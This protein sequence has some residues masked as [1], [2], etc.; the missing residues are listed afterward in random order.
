MSVSFEISIESDASNSHSSAEVLIVEE[1][2][3]D[4]ANHLKHKPSYNKPID[5]GILDE[6]YAVN[7]IDRDVTKLQSVAKP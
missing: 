3:S 7:K 5:S 4:Q 1:I 2:K 6:H